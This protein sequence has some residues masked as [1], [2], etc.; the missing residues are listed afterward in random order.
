MFVGALV[1]PD[2]PLTWE[3]YYGLIR[4]FQILHA[5]DRIE[6]M[7]KRWSMFAATR[8]AFVSQLTDVLAVALGWYHARKMLS[9]LRIPGTDNAIDKGACGLPLCETFAWNACEL[10]DRLLT[11]YG[12]VTP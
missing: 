8:E 6:S 12:G 5:R 9:R 3:G 11:K 1:M 7:R 2:D 4:M 10:A